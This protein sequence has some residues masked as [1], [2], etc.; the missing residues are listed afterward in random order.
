MLILSERLHSVTAHFDQLRSLRFQEAVNK[1][2]PRRKPRRLV[3]AKPLDSSFSDESGQTNAQK[4]LV[5][6]QLDDTTRA[7]QVIFNIFL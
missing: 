1:A 2:I 7:L 5:Q 4:S 6:E 3:D